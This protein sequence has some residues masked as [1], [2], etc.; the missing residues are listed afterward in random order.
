MFRSVMEYLSKI[1]DIVEVEEKEG[2]GTV[3]RAVPMT[4]DNHVKE[5]V[6]NQVR[7]FVCMAKG[8][9]HQASS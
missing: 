1:P 4:C 3:L 8:Y 9:Q 6:A 5:L 2:E 7:V